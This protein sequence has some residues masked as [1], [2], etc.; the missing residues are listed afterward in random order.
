MEIYRKIP[1]WINGKDGVALAIVVGVKGSTPREVGAKMLISEDGL[2]EGTIGGGPVEA[3]VISDAEEVIKTR[4]PAVRIYNL[5]DPN[6]KS[7][8]MICG[9]EMSVYIEPLLVPPRIY[10]FGGGHVGYAMYR[11]ALLLGFHVT[12]IDDRKEYIGKDRFPEAESIHGEFLKVVR[13]IKFTSP[14]YVIIMTRCHDIDEKVLEECLRKD[15]DYFYIGMIGSKKKA[16]EIKKKLLSRGIPESKLEKVHSPIGI[17]IGS[18]SPEEI[19]VSIISEII[20]EKNE[21]SFIC[22]ND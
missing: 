12:V 21:K 20:K 18:N 13:E 4:Q 3:L 10:I 19:S 15:F 11:Q 7:T 16:S 5:N 8:G 6:K 22:S 17:P 14:A 1:H 9:G 2:I